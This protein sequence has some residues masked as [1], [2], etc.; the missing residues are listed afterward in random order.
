MGRGNAAVSTDPTQANRSDR[1]DVERAHAE[2]LRPI[3]DWT[4]TWKRATGVQ[5]ELDFRATLQH[6]KGWKLRGQLEAIAVSKIPR[7]ES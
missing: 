4:R 6:L 2:R 3:S 1:M 7:A 5:G